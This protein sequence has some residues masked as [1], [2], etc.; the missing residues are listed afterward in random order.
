MLFQ[1]GWCAKVEGYLGL[2]EIVK[3]LKEQLKL[4]YEKLRP[5]QIETIQKIIDTFEFG[6]GA[7]YVKLPTGTGKTRI[8]SEVIK[9][10]G[11]KTVVF[12]PR[13][14]LLE[15]TKES[16]VEVGVKENHIDIIS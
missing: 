12:V 11:K 3:G 9:G 13:T 6:D 16:L 2:P 10:T 15:Y 4:S 1:H 5:I 8:M 14:N 7:G